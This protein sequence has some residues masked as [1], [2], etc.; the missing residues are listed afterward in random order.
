MTAGTRSARALHRL[1]FHPEHG[2][3]RAI[4]SLDD[5]SPEKEHSIPS[6]IGHFMD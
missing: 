5:L 3:I 6:L 1:L 2:F 4:L